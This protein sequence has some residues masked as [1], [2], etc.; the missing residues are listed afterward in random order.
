VSDRYLLSG[1]LVTS[2]VPLP[3]EPLDDAVHPPSDALTFLVEPPADPRPNE[4]HPWDL[5]DSGLAIARVGTGFVLRATGYADFLLDASATTVRCIPRTGCPE[6]IS[7]QLF[8]DQVFPLV[9]HARG[10]F[11][12]HAS[13]VLLPSGVVVGFLGRSGLGK[14]T[15]AASFAA[16]PQHAL[17]G[18]D[19]L[20]IVPST[21]RLSA[22]PSYTSARLWP[23]SAEA[24]FA[25]RG[26][27][28]FVSPR[29]EKRRAELAVAESLHEAPLTRLY[30]LAEGEPLRF[31]PL[32]RAAALFALT[33]HVY[34]LDPSDRTRLAQELAWLE[35][36]VRGVPVAELA[37]PRR[38]EALAEVHAA[39]REDAERAS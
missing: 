21:T 39:V 18:D 5:R 38:F 34:R 14:S 17:F 36:I 31:T 7:T 4:A 1:V 32:R 13:S 16:C 30:L 15:L 23:P 22:L 9:L 8:V 37:Y 35:A 12:F 27:L 20:A 19:C 29:S 24:L 3:C 25:H 6:A 28:P 26:E 2:D 10:R 11:A 33:P